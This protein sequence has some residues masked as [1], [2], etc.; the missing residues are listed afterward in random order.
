MFLF[1]D[2]A[3]TWETMSASTRVHTDTE[4]G[5]HKDKRGFDSCTCLAK[6]WDEAKEIKPLFAKV[7]I[8]LLCLTNFVSTL[9]Q[10]YL[11]I[12][13]QSI[14]DIAREMETPVTDDSD[15]NNDAITESSC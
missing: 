4:K 6:S 13:A 14:E 15:M 3:S 1:A 9:E 2:D 12:L 7:E 11:E 5:K 8:Y 10:D